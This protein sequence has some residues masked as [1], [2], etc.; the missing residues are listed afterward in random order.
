MTKLDINTSSLI[1]QSHPDTMW[2]LYINSPYFE[3][4]VDA[5]VSVIARYNTGNLPTFVSSEYGE[6]RVFLTGPHPEF[7][8]D[9]N[10]DGN[11]YFD[12]FDDRG[13]DWDCLYI[14]PTLYPDGIVL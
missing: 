13:S 1:A 4:S 14:V 3:F 8:E 11:S 9:S 12:G 10:R 7:E 5:N 6:G 2:A